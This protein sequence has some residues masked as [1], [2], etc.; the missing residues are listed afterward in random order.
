MSGDKY[1]IG[2]KSG[3]YLIYVYSSAKD[4]QGRE[5]LVQIEFDYSSEMIILVQ[6]RT[7]WG[8]FFDYSIAQQYQV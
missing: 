2:D 1:T 6:T 8:K 7:S 4:Y 3:C 5:G